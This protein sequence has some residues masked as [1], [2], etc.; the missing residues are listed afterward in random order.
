MAISVTQSGALLRIEYDSGEML[1]KDKLNTLVRVSPLDSDCVELL[2]TTE[3]Q[4]ERNRYLFANYS[5]FSAPTGGSAIVVRDAI[6]ALLVDVSG[7]GSAVWGGIT[8]T[9]SDQT[10][11]QAALDAK[12]DENTPITGATKTKITYDSKGLVTAGADATTADISDSTNKRYVTD[13]N[14]VVIGNTSGTNTGDQTSIVGI[15]GTKAQYNTSCSDGDFVYTDNAALTDARNQKFYGSTVQALCSS[16]GSD[17]VLYAL[18]MPVMT[19]GDV[20]EFIVQLR[21]TSSANNKIYKAWLNTTNSLSGSPVQ[22][23]TYTATTNVAAAS[24]QRRLAVR[25][26][27]SVLSNIA[28]ATSFLNPYANSTVLPPEITGLPSLSGTTYL[29]ISC[30]R[31]NSGDVAGAE[32]CKPIL[33]KQ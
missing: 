6:Q 10:D 26:D 9:L 3:D 25:S 8:G 23:A 33:Y 31:A 22:I 14:L 29:I 24:F 32:W 1:V 2:E 15:T 16:T 17:E 4:T 13:A 27:T 28:A 19:T 30:N 21:C 12:V 11:L 20:F 18:L 7:G 5:Q